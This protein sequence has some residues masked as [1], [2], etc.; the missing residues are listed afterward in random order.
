MTTFFPRLPETRD[1]VPTQHDNASLS[2][3][4][5]TPR[6][7]ILIVDDDAVI[8]ATARAKLQSAGYLV[9]T[10]TDGP[11]AIT[12]LGMYRPDVILLDFNFP[13]DV[14]HGGI[15]S[16]DGVRVMSW[17]TRLPGAEHAHFVFITAEEEATIK[18][19]LGSAP[20][21]PVFQKPIDFDRLL[22]RIAKL[23]P[24]LA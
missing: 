18:A 14:P 1:A 7:T 22:G 23:V 19:H 20:G 16:W 8:L 4:G 5:T 3:P 2:A 12:V 17:L 21:I 24:A 10:A 9:L 11:S 15:V 13:P 6:G